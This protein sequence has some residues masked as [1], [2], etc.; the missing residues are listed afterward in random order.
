MGTK[1]KEKVQQNNFNNNR[2]FHNK[3]II[4]CNKLNNRV[5]IIIKTISIFHFTVKL[6]STD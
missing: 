2:P 5:L 3:L 4:P 1:R 6:S